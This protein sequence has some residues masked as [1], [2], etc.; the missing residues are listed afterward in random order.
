MDR[1]GRWMDNGFIERLWRSLKYGCVYLHASETGSEMGAGLARWIGYH[2]GSR[3]HCSLGGLTPEQAYVVLA[4]W[5][6]KRE[7]GG[8]N[9]TR[10]K[11]SKAAKLSRLWGPPHTVDFTA[12]SGCR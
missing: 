4:A 11:L 5:N 7:I 9:S 12:H 2:N 8:I 6:E 10:T 3:P 1:R